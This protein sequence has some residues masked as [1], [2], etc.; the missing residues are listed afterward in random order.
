MF[1]SDDPVSHSH[2]LLSLSRSQLPGCG[3][4]RPK[5]G[6]E[7]SVARAKRKH[8]QRTVE[9]IEPHASEIRAVVSTDTPSRIGSLTMLS[10][11][12]VDDK[13]HEI[14][15]VVPPPAVYYLS[16]CA[17]ASISSRRFRTGRD[18]SRVLDQSSR[19][20]GRHHPRFECQRHLAR[21][22]RL[23]KL[24]GLASC[25]ANDPA[26]RTVHDMMIESRSSCAM[27]GA[28]QEVAQARHEAP[29][30]KHCTISVILCIWEGP[31]T[32]RSSDEP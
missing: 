25:L 1:Q 7:S 24:D 22:K 10:P 8:T 15:V 31:P 5:R 3:R 27:E 9:T 16:D 29:A 28:V 4:R 2:S 13:S 23:V 18:G 12:T 20:N 6:Y 19:S 26:P 17:I 32:N 21:K 14:H 11:C 30:R